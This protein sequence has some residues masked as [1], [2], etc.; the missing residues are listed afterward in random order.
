MATF[1]IHDLMVSLTPDICQSSKK[2]IPTNIFMCQ[3][4]KI[5]TCIG[6]ADNPDL[7]KLRAQL[8]EA[9]FAIQER[10]HE[11]HGGAD[12]Q[13]KKATPGELDQLEERLTEALELIRSQR[14]DPEAEHA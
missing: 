9:L 5:V 4:S 10:E 13:P 3:G 14:K 11:L 7:A 8:I 2:I 1:K 6:N 12:G